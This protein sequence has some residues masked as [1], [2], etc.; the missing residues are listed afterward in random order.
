LPPSATDR[1]QEKGRK[2]NLDKIFF[3]PDFKPARVY[4]GRTV[5]GFGGRQIIFRVIP[6]GEVIRIHAGDG[7]SVYCSDWAFVEAI[8]AD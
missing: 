7:T 6:M 8:A 3:T 1:I 5:N 2:K 4:A